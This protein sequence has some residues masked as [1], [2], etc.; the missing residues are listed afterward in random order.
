MCGTVCQ[1]FESTK[2]V[3]RIWSIGKPSTSVNLPA[4]IPPH[5]F[6]RHG[7]SFWLWWVQV[8]SLHAATGV[9]GALYANDSGPCSIAR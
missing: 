1:A 6:M 4:D 9:S 2:H 7:L 5:V 8:R 3:P